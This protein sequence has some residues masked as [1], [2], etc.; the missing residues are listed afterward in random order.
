MAG[1]RQTAL[2]LSAQGQKLC[3]QA[4][5]LLDFP[6]HIFNQGYCLA[7]LGEKEKA[8]TFFLE[9]FTLF[10]SIGKHDDT[11]YGIPIINEQFGYTFSAI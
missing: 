5:Y 11:V 1:K 8:K 7:Q 9:A 2:E 6:Y 10:D 4:N 3:L